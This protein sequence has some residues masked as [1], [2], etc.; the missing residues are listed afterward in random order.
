MQSD[1]ASLSVLV[2]VAVEESRRE[3]GLA[4][5]LPIAALAARAVVTFPARAAIATI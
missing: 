4:A 5:A 1:V 3:F 2:V